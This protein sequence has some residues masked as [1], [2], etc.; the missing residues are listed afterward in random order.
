MR[1]AAVCGGWLL[2]AAI[3]WLSLAAEP[4]DPGPDISDKVK[5]VVA[6]A[7]LM[8]WFA[9]LYRSGRARAAYA[10]LWIAMGVT[11]EFA[12]SAT[13]YRAYEL[14][15]MAANTL[16]VLAGALAALSR[17]RAAA[18]AGKETP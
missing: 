18:T 17:P 7:A 15:D 4:P 6:Y 12:Q 11:L 16:G 5:H 14:A 2:A 13:G 1:I 8:F 10:L 9:L 3:V